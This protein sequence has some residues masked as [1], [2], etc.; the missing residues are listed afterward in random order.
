MR[1]RD[2]FSYSFDSQAPN[3]P[4]D[5]N[6]GLETTRCLWVRYTLGTLGCLIVIGL[7]LPLLNREVKIN[8]HLYR[9]ARI[10]IPS[11]NTWT[12]L[13]LSPV[14]ISSISITRELSSSSIAIACIRNF[15]RVSTILLSPKARELRGTIVPFRFSMT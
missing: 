9:F 6:G 13:R 12:P 15:A 2:Y 8:W 10:L 7:I 3:L 4:N 14:S 5:E 1:N 11:N